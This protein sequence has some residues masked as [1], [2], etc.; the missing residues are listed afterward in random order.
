MTTLTTDEKKATVSKLL[1]KHTG[2]L[3]SEMGKCIVLCCNCHAKRH[4]A[5]R[6]RVANAHNDKN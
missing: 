4:N 2:Y 1:G 3:L 6:R 5:S